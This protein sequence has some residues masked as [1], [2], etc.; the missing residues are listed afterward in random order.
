MDPS[1]S[2]WRARTRAWC[3]HRSRTW[4][5]GRGSR[6]RRGASPWRDGGG[7][8]ASRTRPRGGCPWSG[9]WPRLARAEGVVH[10]GNRSRQQL[11]CPRPV[12]RAVAI[13]SDGR[14]MMSSSSPSV[15][16]ALDGSQNSSAQKWTNRG[17]LSATVVFLPQVLVH[18]YYKCRN[19]G[20]P[21]KGTLTSISVLGSAVAS[22]PHRDT[23]GQGRQ[24]PESIHC[25]ARGS[26]TAGGQGD[27]DGVRAE[28]ERGWESCARSSRE[29]PRRRLSRSRP[30]SSRFRFESSRSSRR[31][32]C[33]TARVS[34]Y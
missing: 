32:T 16:A 3:S 20:L 12:A 22:N 7:V 25:A 10:L 19:S 5:T 1:A 31:P 24:R 17:N 23:T 4:Q 14:G 9:T 28:N 11:S 13:S 15:T 6:A 8:G 33:G 34:G 2:I 21:L 18:R 27:T 29:S 30:R 26:R